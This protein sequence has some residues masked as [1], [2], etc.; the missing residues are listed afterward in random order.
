MLRRVVVDA[1]CGPSAWRGQVVDTALLSS[2]RFNANLPRTKI[3]N[4]QAMEAFTSQNYAVAVQRWTE[5]LQEIERT[6]PPGSVATAGPLNNL[7]CVY[8]EVGD[9]YQQQALLKRIL[10]LTQKNYGEDHVQYAITL[11]NLAS[12]CAG[13]GQFKA[14]E[15]YCAQSKEIN[16]KRFGE[17]HAKVARVMILEAEAKEGLGKFDE[18]VA[19]LEDA[20][21]IVRKHCGAKHNQVSITIGLLSGAYINLKDPFKA[22]EVAEEAI[23]IDEN[24]YG[25]RHPQYALSQR[26]LAR[27]MD[28]AGKHQEA[29]EL[30]LAALM[31]QKGAV[32]ADDK[33]Q[34]KTHWG[35]I[36]CCVALKELAEAQSTA[37]RA[38]MLC[39]G[40]Y[41][42]VH[43]TVGR[44]ELKSAE[45]CRL[46]NDYR[47]WVQH[48]KPAH[49]I[50]SKFYEK[51]DTPIPDVAKAKESMDAAIAACK[52]QGL[53]FLVDPP[54]EAGEEEEEPNADGKSDEEDWTKQK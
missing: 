14:M 15:E 47:H 10:D 53:D 22:V 20:L 29:K 51:A 37:Q 41:S 18:Q 23:R 36:D 43:A 7:A 26:S 16:A 46:L 52:A 50:L 2:R 32:G 5:M 24:L 33:E 40:Q 45:V 4:N 8:G 3:L 30:F 17:R 19:L 28:A 49:D 13:L 9:Y 48:A 38:L 1:L 25:V 21:Q 44:A 27:A 31:L 54:P 34:I 11:Y 12:S 35:I 6:A 39:H 42:S